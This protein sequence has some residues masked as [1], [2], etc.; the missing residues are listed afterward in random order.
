MITDHFLFDK[1][2]DAHSVGSIN[3][4]DAVIFVNP[5]DYT[6]EYDLIPG[7]VDKREE[8]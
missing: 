5:N 4:D 1:D 3:S 2:D 6:L 7:K 8:Q